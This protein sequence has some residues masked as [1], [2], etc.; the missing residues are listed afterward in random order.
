MNIRFQDLSM[1]CFKTKIFFFPLE[2][3]YHLF[4]FPQVFCPLYY[5]LLWGNLLLDVFA[6]VG[7]LLPP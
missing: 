5:K 1:G 4:S 3:L 6:H 2:L 7:P